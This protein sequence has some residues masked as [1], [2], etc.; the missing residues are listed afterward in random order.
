MT[1]SAGELGPLVGL[2]TM[3]VTTTEV[4]EL[5]RMASEEVEV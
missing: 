5:S 3:R 4:T 2:V 1:A